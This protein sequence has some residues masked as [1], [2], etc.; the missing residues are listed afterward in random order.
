MLPRMKDNLE[1]ENT[2]KTALC[3]YYAVC[4]ENAI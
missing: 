4:V 3:F 1:K 2:N